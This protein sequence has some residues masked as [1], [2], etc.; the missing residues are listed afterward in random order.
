MA[1]GVRGT[2]QAISFGIEDD[3]VNSEDR[4]WMATQKW[5][6]SPTFQMWD[7]RANHAIMR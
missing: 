3:R 2:A 6:R 4:S 5:E 1:G 7:N